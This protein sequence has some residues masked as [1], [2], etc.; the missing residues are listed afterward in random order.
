MSSGHITVLTESR[1]LAQNQPSA[2]VAALNERDARIAVA[3]E[4]TQVDDP[5]CGVVLRGR[6]Q[7]LL[8]RAEQFWKAGVPI[9]DAP[10]AIRQVRNKVKM[11]RLL[12]KHGLPIPRAWVGTDLPEVVPAEAYPVIA[13]PIRGDNARGIQIHTTSTELASHLDD[14]PALLVQPY[15]PSSGVDLKLY[16]I[17]ESITAVHKPSPVTDRITSRIG[18]TEVTPMMVDIVHR[19][20]EAFG[21]TLFGVDCLEIDGVLVVIEVNDFPNFTAVPDAGEL[22]ADHVMAS[23]GVE[24]GSITSPQAPKRPRRSET[25]PGFDHTTTF[26]ASSGLRALTDIASA[27]GIPQEQPWEK[28]QESPR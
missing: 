18:A 24:P 7:P 17:G 15:L 2:L 14:D 4:F 25:F 22:L 28:F 21:L 12:H 9:I 5:G 13:K 26:E 23:F 1:Y 3:T 10:K 6:S 19:C 16:V 8:R 20:R 27:V 11:T